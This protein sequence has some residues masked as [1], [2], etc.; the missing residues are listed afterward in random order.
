MEKIVLE[1]FLPAVLLTFCL[2][3]IVSVLT[4]P[5]VM[6]ADSCDSAWRLM[7][8]G[9]ALSDDSDQEAMYYQ[10]AATLCPDLF[11]VRVRLGRLYK[12]QGKLDQ[13]ANVLKDTVT[14]I[15]SSDFFMT[16]PGSK[17]ILIDAMLSLG[18]VYRMQG[19]LDLA[20]QQY[21]KVLIMFPDST[22]A[23]NQIEY[24]YKRLHKFDAVPAPRYNLLTNPTFTRI[25]GF[26]LPKG[27]FLIDTQYRFWIQDAPLSPDQ[28]ETELPLIPPE[29]RT[30]DIHMWEAGVRYGIT[31]KFSVGVVAKYFS[32]KVQ[33]KSPLFWGM[34][35]DTVNLRVSGFGDTVI[36]LKY[37]VWGMRKKHLSVYNLLSL[38]TGDDDATDSDGFI[39][40]K[41]PLGS[42]SFDNTPGI[43]FTADFD[44]FITNFNVSY[45][46]TNG[47]NVGDEFNMGLALSYP[48]KHTMFASLELGYRWRDDVRIKQY[49][50]SYIY[51]PVSRGGM[52]SGQAWM[53]EKGGS[54]FFI[55]PGV[56]LMVGRGVKFEVGVKVPVVKPDNSW[57]E[58]FVLLAGISKAFF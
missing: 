38:P 42:G 46:I 3:C 15:L 19:R 31:D 45:R 54:T 17:K 57:I 35:S 12:N 1:R 52:V 44:P 23:Q 16:R 25:S 29:E 48:Y 55:E 40:R 21:S 14:D 5:C 10:E 50:Q 33:L 8:Q 37:H 53:T 36:M 28:F 22:A 7:N 26:C 30:A 32:R 20:E 39:K 6:A 2:F 41:I 49:I 34:G 24:V 58:D 27:K 11:E 13:A 56:Q 47:E 4:T 18:E 51:R 43:A 9:I